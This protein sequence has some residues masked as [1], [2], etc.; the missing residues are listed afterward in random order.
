M[1]IVAEDVPTDI[2]GYQ[3][4]GQKDKYLTFTL[5]EEIYGIPISSVT[6][7]IGIQKITSVPDMPEYVRGVINLRGQV[8]PLMDVRV[9]FCMPP[10]EY[11]ERTCVVVVQV[12]GVSIGLVVD[13]VNEVSNIPEEERSDPPRIAS[14]TASR[15]IEGMGRSDDQVKILLSVDKLLFNEELKELGEMV[16]S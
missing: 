13:T 10:R 15:Y 9:R 1:N 6:E 4:D 11:D 5:G 3:E 2:G 12:K 16:E 8:I 7:I 14:G